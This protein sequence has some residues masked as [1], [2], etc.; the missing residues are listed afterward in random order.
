MAI[1]IP[2]DLVDC[3]QTKGIDLLSYEDVE[4]WAEVTGAHLAGITHSS[5][6]N[7]RHRKSAGHHQL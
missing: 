5:V 7:K 3:E 4:S 2:K 1:S 6:T